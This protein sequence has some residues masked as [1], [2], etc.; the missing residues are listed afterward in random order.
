MPWTTE[1]LKDK[2]EDQ[3]EDDEHDVLRALAELGSASAS[4]LVYLDLTR[5]IVALALKRLR[6]DRAAQTTL[7]EI[8][9]ALRDRAYCAGKL[10]HTRCPKRYCYSRD[11]ILHMIDCCHLAKSVKRGAEALPFLLHMARA[12]KSIPGHPPRPYLEPLSSA[13]RHQDAAPPLPPPPP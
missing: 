12:T 7:T 3:Y 10:Y 4:I 11:S 6:E 1:E 8:L 5:E 13:T 9:S 2:I